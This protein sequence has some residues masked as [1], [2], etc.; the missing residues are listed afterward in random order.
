MALKK[1]NQ[2]HFDQLKSG[3]H[4]C[5]ANLVFQVGREYTFENPSDKTEKL[6]AKCTQNCP[7]ALLKV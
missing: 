2:E 3:Y 6:K 4:A 7:F 1:L 5:P